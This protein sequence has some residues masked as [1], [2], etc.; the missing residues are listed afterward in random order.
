[1]AADE[2]KT[3][4]GSTVTLKS[5]GK[6]MTPKEKLEYLSAQI[7]LERFVEKHVIRKSRE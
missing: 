1:V 3:V 4:N 5:L 2:K 7:E 6:K